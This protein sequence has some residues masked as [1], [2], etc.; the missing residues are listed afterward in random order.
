MLKNKTQEIIKTFWVGI[1][2][3]LPFFFVGFIIWKIAELIFSPLLPVIDKLGTWLGVTDFAEVFGVIILIA[4]IFLVGLALRLRI[5]KKYLT[6]FENKLLFYIP[7][8]K[9]YQA[10]VTTPSDAE[11]KILKPCLLKED[12]LLKVCFLVEKNAEW[13]TLMV[14]EAP[15][16]TT[17]ELMVVPLSKITPLTVSNFKMTGIIRNYGEGIL[18]VLKKNELKL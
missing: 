15:T 18:D 2:F 13:A 12:G 17:G 4:F 3:I 6:E 11:D 7:G 14:P 5:L 9:F 10:L 8:Y 1:S 16:F